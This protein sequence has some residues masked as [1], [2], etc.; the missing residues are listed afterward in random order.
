MRSG[1]PRAIDEAKYFGKKLS[2]L[3]SEGNWDPWG[4]TNQPSIAAG[5]KAARKEIGDIIQK[6]LN[7]AETLTTE[8]QTLG[9]DKVKG[10]RLYGGPEGQRLYNS[11][12]GSPD[13][14]KPALLTRT[15]GTAT[16]DKIFQ[17]GMARWAKV[18]NGADK[19][20]A[21]LSQ[22]AQGLQ[23]YYQGLRYA[24]G[25]DAIGRVMG[26]AVF[27]KAF[28]RRIQLPP[29]VDGYAYAMDQCQ[30]T[31]WLVPILKKALQ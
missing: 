5:Q 26:A 7:G 1:N 12:W 23:A 15:A 28:G 22:F 19:G 11:Y 16:A 24:R 2:E 17:D 8:W 6:R 4:V 9:G 29:L 27:R 18:L 13:A 25:G 14:F 30:F 21:A 31:E 3:G 20:D 10:V